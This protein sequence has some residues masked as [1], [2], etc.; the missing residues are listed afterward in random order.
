MKKILLSVVGVSLIFSSCNSDKTIP[1]NDVTGFNIATNLFY[2]NLDVNAAN[3]TIDLTNDIESSAIFYKNS[4]EVCRV[5]FNLTE[6][7]I[8]VIKSYLANL[9]YKTS[10]CKNCPQVEGSYNITFYKHKAIVLSLSA[11]GTYSENK[12]SYITGGWAEIKAYIK[13]IL[14][15]EE[16]SC[17]EA[18]DYAF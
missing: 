10:T 8:N 3:I 4:E 12:I 1:V 15:A 16:L 9:T 5:G 7:Q 13:E 14:E 17:P 11:S 2:T 18:W 6:E